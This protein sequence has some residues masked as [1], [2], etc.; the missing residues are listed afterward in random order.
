MVRLNI[1]LHEGIARPEGHTDEDEF[2]QATNLWFDADVAPELLL[3]IIE[4]GMK[5]MSDFF[6]TCYYDATRFYRV[7]DN[8]SPGEHWED[9]TELSESFSPATPLYHCEWHADVDWEKGKHF[10]ILGE[11]FCEPM[12]SDELVNYL[13]A[14]VI[15]EV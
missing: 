9:V 10:S 3:E 5:S 6:E 13:K 11:G 7:W 12:A 8:Y 14:M 15:K 4:G 2:V 1:A